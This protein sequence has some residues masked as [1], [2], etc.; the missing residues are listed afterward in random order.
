MQQALRHGEIRGR[1]GSWLG[2]LSLPWCEDSPWP[3]RCAG[4]TT[5]HRR[6]SARPGTDRPRPVMPFGRMVGSKLMSRHGPSRSASICCTTSV[7]TSTVSPILPARP[8]SGRRSGS[9]GLAT[10]TTMVQRCGRLRDP[11]RDLLRREV[12]AALGEFVLRD[13]H[14]LRRRQQRPSHRVLGA[15]IVDEDEGVEAVVGLLRIAGRSRARSWPR[16]RRPRF[17]D[18]RR[19]NSSSHPDPC[20]PKR[21]AIHRRPAASP[22]GRTAHRSSRCAIPRR[23][24]VEICSPMPRTRTVASGAFGIGGAEIE[25]PERPD[26][27][28]RRRPGPARAPRRCRWIRTRR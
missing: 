13:R 25:A 11:L 27:G 12:G 15:G 24:A 21:A 9:P 6:P 7:P 3:R 17:P 28:R 14:G 26:T 8:C 5:S 20:W 1:C 22:P 10:V 23:P 2:R 19:R 16:R 18:A 4:R